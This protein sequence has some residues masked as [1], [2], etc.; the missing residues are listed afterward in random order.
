MVVE[1]VLVTVEAPKTAKLCTEAS[2]GLANATEQA[3]SLGRSE[4]R[5]PEICFS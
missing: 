1:P 3:E 4:P 5:A 2:I